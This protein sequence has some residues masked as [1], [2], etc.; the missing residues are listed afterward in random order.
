M[1]CFD[2][3]EKAELAYGGYGTAGNDALP[4]ECLDGGL[5]LLLAD[6]L[7]SGCEDVDGCLLRI[8]T[9]P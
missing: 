3:R 2:N 5:L 6:A 1:M 7:F 4:H 9:Y 8:A